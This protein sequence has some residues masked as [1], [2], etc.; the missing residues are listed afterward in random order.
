MK[1]RKIKKIQKYLTYD[2]VKTLVQ[3]TVTVYIENHKETAASLECRST[4]YRQ[5]IT[6]RINCTYTYSF[7][8]ASCH[9]AMSIQVNIANLQNFTWHYS[10]DML[11]WYH[12]VGPLTLHDP[13][14]GFK[15][16]TPPL[17]FFALTHLILELHYCALVTFP[18]K[19]V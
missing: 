4:T 2:A 18:K 12:P 15:S 10:S 11:N 9:K 1:I 6:T 5:A 17:S 3:C 16:P 7:S 13:G 14:G 19:I 8:L